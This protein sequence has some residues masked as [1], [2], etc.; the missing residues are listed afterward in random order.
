MSQAI[1]RQML[2]AMELF[3]Y[4]ARFGGKTFL[5]HFDSPQSFEELLTDLRLLESA[6]IKLVL[7]FSPD[8]DLSDLK[9]S[10]EWGF[11]FQRLIGGNPEQ[12]K[13]AL[14]QGAVPLMQPSGLL[15]TLAMAD[16]LKAEKLL[17]IEGQNPLAAW[18]EAL[19]HVHLDEL[20]EQGKVQLG[21]EWSQPAR[22]NLD[23]AFVPALSGN[24]YLE[25]FTHQGSGTLVTQSLDK[26][27]RQASLKDVMD[28]SLLMK[29]YIEDK[30]ILPVSLDEIAAEIDHYRVAYVNQELVAT[31]RLKPWENSFELSKFCTLPRYRGKGTAR[32]LCERLIKDAR[33]SEAKLLFALSI[34]Q[35]MWKFFADFGL[36]E[37]DKS[38]L[39]PDWREG[40]DVNRPSRALGMRL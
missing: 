38:E 14:E 27:I 4:A 22:K 33:A 28:I 26:E 17:F 29:P 1:L 24:L 13:Q 30:I 11:P 36:S 18:G 8:A 15:E 31:A 39:P 9:E 20:I 19:S 6:K 32:A 2:G 40:Y 35:K 7:L 12:T 16:Y 25:I 5:I 37:I 10:Q 34:D 21:D 23:L 3:H